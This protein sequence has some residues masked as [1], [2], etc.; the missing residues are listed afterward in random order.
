MIAVL[1]IATA[2]AA[3]PAA[4]DTAEG[5]IAEARDHLLNG[6]PLPPDMNLRL[7]RLDPAPRLRVLI[8]L[9]RAGIFEGPGWTAEML[10]AAPEPGGAR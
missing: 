5:L 3:P 6:E 7:R 8:F 4:P 1:L 2:L 10:L 9:R